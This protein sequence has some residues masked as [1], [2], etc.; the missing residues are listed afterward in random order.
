MPYVMSDHGNIVAILWA[1]HNPLHAP[2]LPNVS[3]KILWV[4][5]T[6]TTQLRI[7]ARPLDASSPTVT[8]K[9]PSTAGNQTPSI[10]DLPSPGCWS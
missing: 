8:L 1:D 10:V 2:P 6:A 7:V 5:Q 3:N 4:T 9:Y